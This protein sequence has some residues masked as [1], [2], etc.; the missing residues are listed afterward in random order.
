LLKSKLRFMIFDF[1]KDLNSR[2]PIVCDG[3][4][5][6]TKLIIFPEVTRS[7][8]EEIVAA[9]ERIFIHGNR[10]QQNFGVLG[11]CLVAGGAIVIP[12]REVF[13]RVRHRA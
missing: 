2:V 3:R 8:N 5:H 4:Y 9:S 11:G 12:H 13:D 7:Q 6:V 1:I 10:F